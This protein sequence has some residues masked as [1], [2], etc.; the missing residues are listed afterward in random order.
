MNAVPRLAIVASDAG[1]VTNEMPALLPERDYQLRL[2]HWRTSK[3][4]GR[5]NK[6]A[7]WFK[8]MDYGDTFETLVPRYYNVARLVGKP[9]RGGRFKASAGGDLVRD[10]ARLLALPYRFDRLNLSALKDYIIV[11]QVGTVAFTAKQEAL[12]PACQYSVVRKLHRIES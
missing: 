11:G 9:G 1:E 7:L 8:V 4:F 10:Y 6:L 3:L 2:D 5:A 12:A